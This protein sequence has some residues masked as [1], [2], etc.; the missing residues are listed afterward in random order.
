MHLRVCVSDLSLIFTYRAAPILCHV[1]RV[2][3]IIGTMREVDDVI[4]RKGGLRVAFPLESPASRTLR[5]STKF[6]G[7]L[8]IPKNST[9]RLWGSNWRPCAHRTVELPTEPTVRA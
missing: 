6:P 1:T 8:Q 9:R 5:S 4:G 2:I 3:F 7:N